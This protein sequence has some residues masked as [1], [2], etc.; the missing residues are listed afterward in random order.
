MGS[1]QPDGDLALRATLCLMD[2]GA[3]TTAFG[4]VE[5]VRNGDF[6]AFQ[7]LFERYQHRLA[8]LIHYRLGAK[9]RP[10]IDVDDVMQETFLEAF[11]DIVKFEYRSP[12]AFFRWLNAVAIHVVE[13]AARHAGRRKRDGGVR[14][15]LR[16]ESSPGGADP[17]DSLTPSRI[18]FQHERIQLL[19]RRLDELPP[20]YREVI[21]LAKVEGLETSEISQRLGKPR[22]AVAL[23]LHRALKSFRAGAAQ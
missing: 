19:M 23:L 2:S 16:S 3:K 20:Q 6:D 10:V 15:P 7:A 14:V 21:I 22:E 11:Q 8:V 12:G 18:L 5:R 17:A 13:D 1:R 4:L 9:L